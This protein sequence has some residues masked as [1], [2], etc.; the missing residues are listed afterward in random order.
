MINNGFQLAQLVKK[1]VKYEIEF[2][3]Q[4]GLIIKCNYHVATVICLNHIISIKKI[5]ETNK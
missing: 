2:E 5:N 1:L 3:C 4:I